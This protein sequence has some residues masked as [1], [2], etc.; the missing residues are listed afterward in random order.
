MSDWHAR[1][2]R[3]S[4]PTLFPV[5]LK[6]SYTLDSYKSGIKNINN[7]EYSNILYAKYK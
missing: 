3:L 7:K 2:L 1:Y 5:I 6:I 4:N